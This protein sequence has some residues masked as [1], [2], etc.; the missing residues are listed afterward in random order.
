MGVGVVICTLEY[1]MHDYWGVCV[2]RLM[3]LHI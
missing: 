2:L 1:C 3:K